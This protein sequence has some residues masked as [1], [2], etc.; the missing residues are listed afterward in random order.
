MNATLHFRSLALVVTLLFAG[1]AIAQVQVS[2]TVTDADT[3]DSLP[4]ANVV[5]EGTTMGAATDQ[6]GRYTISGVPSGTHTLTVSFIGYVESSKVITVRSSNVT[7]DFRVSFASQSL[8]ALE[9]FASR[10]VDRKTP[11]AFTNVDKIQ[12]QREL[13]SRDAP[14]VLNTAPSVYATAQGGGAGDARMNVRGFNQR[15]VAIMLNGVPVNDMENGW[16]Y[17]SNWDGVGDATSSIQLQRGLSAVNLATPSIGGTMNIITDPSAN[18]RQVL[19]KQEVGNDGFLKSTVSLSTGLIDGKYAFTVSGVRKTGDGY[20]DGTWTD[21]WAYYAAA[22]W[23]INSKHRLD[24]YAVGAPQ[25]HGQ[26]LYRQNIAAYDHDYAREVMEDDG[27]SSADIDAVLAKFPEAGRRWNENVSSVSS[28]YG[29]FGNNGFGSVDRNTSNQLNERENF[30]HKPQLNLN[31]YAQISDK[32]LLS[33]VLYYSGGKGGGTGTKGDMTWDYS[34]PSRVVNYDATISVNQSG[35]DRKGNPKTNGVSNAILRNSHNVQYTIGVISKF[36]HE[37]NENTTVEVGVDWRTAE[38]QHYRSVRDLLGGSSYLRFDNDFWGSG[39]KQLQAGD[40]FDYNNTNTVNWIG[41]FVQGE[42]TKDELTTYG[43]A[44][45]SLVKYTFEDLFRDD[46]GSPFKAESDNI[47]GYQIK[48]GASYATNDNISFYGNA[49]VVSKVP[50]FDGAIDDQTGT[51]NPDPKNEQFIAFEA[52]A[53]YRSTDRSLT[54]KLNVYHTIWNDR[55]ITRTVIEASGD[56]GIINISGLNAL[57]QGIEAEVAY[58]PHAMVRADVAVSLG[59]WEYT[60]DVSAR[61]TPD[62]SNPGSQK[63]VNLY[64]KDIKVGDAPQTQF[65]YALTFFPVDGMYAKITGRSYSNYYADFDPTSRDDASDREQSW[66]IP[67][68][69]VFDLNVGYDIPREMLKA[70][71]FDI[72]VFANVFNVFDSFYIQDA[73]DNSRYNAYGD[74]GVNHRADDAEVHLGLPRAFNFGTRITFR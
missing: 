16:V 35:L 14:L 13:G 45:Y 8:Q 20:Y 27:V 40:K 25:R 57:H 42:Y 58:Q 37:L 50:I 32:S 15:N 10:A 24:F 31:H 26:N 63:T 67:A 6:D 47:G 49:G 29:E 19:V 53:T 5:I 48:G 72:R 38:I 39:G 66:K 55:T 65:A 44:G 11:V 21:A 60:D 23:N 56:D 18:S 59:K 68:Y 1:S 22:A 70:S 9:V 61:Y 51:L 46:G 33:T 17:W 74:N 62:V 64:L 12:M 7:A 36:K 54:G 52:G 34:G 2:G 73:S 28:S 4:G 30:F 41:G 71:R 69:N 3:G 43:M